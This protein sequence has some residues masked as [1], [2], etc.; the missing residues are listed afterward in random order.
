MQMGYDV[1]CRLGLKCT[2]TWCYAVQGFPNA[3]L[4]INDIPIIHHD[5]RLFSAIC[6]PWEWHAPSFLGFVLDFVNWILINRWLVVDSIWVAPWLSPECL[7]QPTLPPI[8]DCHDWCLS[9]LFFLF[10][11]TASSRL[12]IKSFWITNNR[13]IEPE[14]CSSPCRKRYC[15][16]HDWCKKIYYDKHCQRIWTVCLATIRW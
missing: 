11:V 14:E 12:L 1:F 2:F 8:S 9:V 7:G 3:V 13:C 16:R 10:Q 15:N 4:F 5:E 6:Y